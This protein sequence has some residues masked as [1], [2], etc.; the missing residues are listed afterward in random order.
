[1]LTLFDDATIDNWSDNMHFVADSNGKFLQF[2]IESCYRYS[3]LSIP[4]FLVNMPI[5]CIIQELICSQFE[6]TKFGGIT[7]T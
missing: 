6:T 3:L 2:Y 4:Y 7:S 5:A 1:M